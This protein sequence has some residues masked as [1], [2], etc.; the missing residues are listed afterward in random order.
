MSTRAPQYEA[1]E[2]AAMQG[3]EPAYEGEP[4]RQAGPLATR[5]TRP[6]SQPGR[7]DSVLRDPAPA[8]AWNPP[9]P[10]PDL[11]RHVGS[12]PQLAESYQQRRIVARSSAE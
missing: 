4:V 2:R 11:I 9:A 10:R 12:H 8:S 1:D 7:L 5:P 3:E 6:P